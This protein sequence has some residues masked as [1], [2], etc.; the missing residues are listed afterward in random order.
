[1][2]LSNTHFRTTAGSL[3]YRCISLYYYYCNFNILCFLIR[4]RLYAS[5]GH[6]GG[7]VPTD[8]GD[9]K[10]TIHKIIGVVI[11]IVVVV[12]V[13]LVVV[14]VIAVIRI[15]NIWAGRAIVPSSLFMLVLFS[16]TGVGT[17]GVVAEVPQLT[18]MNF[19][20]EMLK[21]VA[22]YCKIV[23]NAATCENEE[24]YYIDRKKHCKILHKSKDM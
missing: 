23:Q 1:M 4:P 3:L 15:L 12:V 2:P 5:E 10:I 13:I 16:R 8:L 17:N 20:G 22:T 18:V 19:H 7:G 11:V 21:H 24:R 9:S 14:I 6:A